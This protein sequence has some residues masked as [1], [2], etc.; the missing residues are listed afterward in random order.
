MVIVAK[1]LVMVVGSV[2]EKP[3]T[4]IEAGSTNP[5]NPRK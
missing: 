3:T 4:T 1:E 5:R 2:R